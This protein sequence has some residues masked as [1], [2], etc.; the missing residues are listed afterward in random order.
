MLY[1]ETYCSVNYKKFKLFLISIFA[2]AF[3]VRANALEL[4]MGCL[5]ADL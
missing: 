3:A 5:M 2:E 1:W 4:R